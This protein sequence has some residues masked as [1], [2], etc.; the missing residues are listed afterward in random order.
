MQT[1]HRSNEVKICLCTMCTYNIQ[2]FKPVTV[3][4][5]AGFIFKNS[6]E[7]LSTDLVPLLYSWPCL[8]GAS[9]NVG[10]GGDSPLHAAVRQDSAEQVAVLLDYGADMNLRDSN[11]QRAV[12]LAPPGGETQQLL[13]AFEGNALT[14]PLVIQ[15]TTFA[16]LYH[17]SKNNPFSFS[18]VSPRTLCHLCRLQI[19]NLIGRSRLKQLPLLPLPPLLTDY[20]E[21]T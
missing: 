8:L 15:R 18:L 3:F 10:R 19:R 17:S 13:Q 16:E 21:H 20:L 2:N 7:I 9:V 5:A 11:N 4:I 1:T 14:Y 12:E 6:F